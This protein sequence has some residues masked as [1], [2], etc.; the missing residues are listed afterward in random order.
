MHIGARAIGS[1]RPCYIIAEAGVNH[2]GRMDLALELIDVAADAG[3]DAIKFQTF[4]ADKVVSPGTR[5]ADYQSRNT[6]GEE[7][8]L[9]MVRRLELGH[10]DFAELARHCQARGVEFLSTPFDDP[11]IDFLAG[12]GMAAF[13]IPS[14]EAVSVPY[15]RR[16]AACGVP[17][18]LSTGMCTMDEVRLGVETLQGAGATDIAILHCVSCYPAPPEESNLKVMTTMGDAFGVP[19]GYSDH[20]LGIE[21]SLAAVALGAT[22]LEKHF[23]LDRAMEGP[24]HAAS[25]EPDELKTLVAGVRAVEA[26]LG[27]GV[28]VPQPSEAD[29]MKVARRSLFLSRPVAKAQVISPDDLMVLRPASG[30]S[31]ADFDN[32][33]GKTA[34]TDLEVGRMLAWDDITAAD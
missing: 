24:D 25:L 16:V 17:V 34:T 10:D 5:K 22:V 9:E 2:N 29:T 27:D 3:V 6:G 18:L 28:K 11:S 14:G 30:I 15:L 8:Q 26:S 4:S 19:V 23:T 33:I 12:L 1:E 7:D 13:K 31:P 32:V 21:V 20:T